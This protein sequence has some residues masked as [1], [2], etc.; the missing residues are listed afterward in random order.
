MYRRQFV[1]QAAGG[2]RSAHDEVF[3]PLRSRLRVQDDRAAIP[4]RRRAGRW[5]RLAADSARAV[6]RLARRLVALDGDGE[7]LTHAL[8]VGRHG[9]RVRPGGICRGQVGG[10][11]H[12]APK[13]GDLPGPP[14]GAVGN[15][16][17][18]LE[19]DEEI[20]T[21]RAVDG[22]TAWTW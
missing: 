16:A 5:R 19:P 9:G 22:L 14:T 15:L 1:G 20:P 6:P 11:D 10:F 7:R 4:Q 13:L 12:R 21:T 17:T 8:L 18:A 3:E 2:D